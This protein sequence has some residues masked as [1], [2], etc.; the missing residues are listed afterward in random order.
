MESIIVL[1]VLAVLAVP[2]LLLVLWLS[3]SSLRRRVA[4][5]EQRVAE[6]QA[7]PEAAATAAPLRTAPAPA[8]EPSPEQPAVLRPR[9]APPPLPEASAAPWGATPAQPVAATAQAASPA[10][11]R[12]VPHSPGPLERFLS[13][14]K[15]WFTEG[16]VPVKVGMLVLLA[17][18]GALLKY[19]SDQ[20]WL[21]LPVEL[22][23]AGIA[24]AALAGLVFGWRQRLAR[25]AFGQALQG[26]AIGVLLLVVFAAFKRYDL[27]PVQAAFAISVLLVAG[28]C[29]LAVLQD[30]RTLAVLGT[31]A[32]FLAPLWLSTG[33]GNHVALFTYY[34]LVNAG[35]FAIAWWRPWRVLNLLGFAFTFGIGTLWGVLSYKPEQFATTEPFLLLFFAFYLIIPVLYARR[36]GGERWID[37]SLVFGAP[38]VA[39][40]LQAGL[41]RGERWP[42]ALCALAVAAVYALLAAW[43]LRDV[44]TRLLGQAHAVLAVG[45]ATLAVPLALSAHATAGVFALEGAGLVWLGLRQQR[46]LPQWSGVALQ[47]A[48]MV[49]FGLALPIHG[50]MLR[51]VANAHFMSGLLIALA[52]FATAWAWRA[53]AQSLPALAAYVWGLGWW[54]GMAS[55]EIAS[56]VQLDARA[57]VALAVAGF[58]GWLAA[59]VHRRRPAAALAAT[60]ALAFLF[61]LP[62]AV[63][64]T[65]LQRPPLAGHGAWAWP[66]FALLGVRA[67]W[68]LRA[69]RDLAFAAAAQFVWWLLWATVATLCLRWLGLHYAL[70][71]GWLLA[72]G[73]A[74][75]LALLAAALLRWRWLAAPLGEAFLPW[76]PW[77]R[78]TAALIVAVIWLASL[79][80][81]LSA[82]PLP[83]LPVLNPGELTQ[84]AALALLL[85]ALWRHAPDWLSQRRVPLAA[86]AGLLWVTMATLRSVHHW[87]DLPWT[88]S[89][90]SAGLSQTSLTVVWSVLGVAGWISGSR[91]HQRALWLAGAVLMA[92]VLAKLVL[93]DR[94]HLGNLLGIGSFIAYGLLCTLVGYIAPAPPRPLA[95]AGQE[96]MA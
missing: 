14:A 62:L 37:G 22:R 94:Q 81:P 12:R 21:R 91:R 36:G 49:A 1:V 40:A 17:G 29:V 23:L 51:P 72:L 82:Q 88:P 33:S 18:V 47:L 64:Q 38:L 54:C 85:R 28:M 30:S 93:V 57:H 5:L 50:E 65:D 84:L 44:R 79:A 92:L 66:L 73:A 35:V 61:A 67:L 52:G 34:A 53:H 25:P 26:G 90:L 27:M 32:G 24:A 70:A 96:E 71:G 89:L 48:A 86:C 11:E 31:L 56:F 77:L 75:W 10:V 59:E 74:P 6:L 42:L 78:A 58:T 39:F 43:C 60:T 9:P 68:C 46:A 83:W 15:R 20:G 80:A 95:A 19:A 87:G 13:A 7:R 45:F 55:D 2:V 8:A 4:G 69:G 76:L 41:L 16:N 63:A 3:L